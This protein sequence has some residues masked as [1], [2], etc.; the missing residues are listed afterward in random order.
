MARSPCVRVASAEDGAERSYAGMYESVLN[1]DADELL[2]VATDRASWQA[3]ET[4]GRLRM[5]RAETASSDV[6]VIVQRMILPAAAGVALTA[7]PISGDRS[8]SVVSAVRGAGDRLV[9]GDAIG[10]E[11]SVR[12]GTATVRRHPE[13]AINRAQAVQVAREASR[14]AADRGVPQDIEWAIDTEGKLWILQA[15]PMTALPPEVSWESPARG[16]YTRQLRFGEWIGEPVTPLFE[17]WLLP[18]LEEGLHAK[19]QAEIGQRA[20]LPHHVIVNGWYFYS[21]NWFSPSLLP[22]PARHA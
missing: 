1:V 3:P 8:L 12:N 4:P 7:D 15:R 18:R 14:I 2:A 13:D 20:P 6:A 19:L 10:D 21:L 5:A 17:S 22:Q 11:W 9:S 16:A